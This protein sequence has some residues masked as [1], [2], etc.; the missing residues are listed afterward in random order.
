MNSIIALTFSSLTTIA[1]ADMIKIL[2]QMGTMA[3]ANN[4]TVGGL[5]SLRKSGPEDRFVDPIL[6]YMDPIL[7]YGCWCHFGADWI[8]AGGK[9][10]D[11]IDL[12]CKQLIQGYRCARMD[13][14]AQNKDCDAGN[15]NYT[16]YNFFFGQDIHADC[17]AANAGDDCAIDAC[18]IEGAF[19]LHFLSDFVSGNI[20]NIA[21]P[22]F[23]TGN[24][25]DREAECVVKNNGQSYTDHEC[26]GE[27]PNRAPYSPSRGLLSCCGDSGL[28]QMTSHDCCVD[29]NNEFSIGLLGNC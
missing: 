26:C 22:Q 9:V 17:A 5:Q 28:Y 13:A 18:V 16:P 11:D 3:K 24:G 21:D 23:Q 2:E 20:V 7:N 6:T 12:R 4:V 29:Q 27:Q 15:I 19:T 10:R 14:R 8:H 25:W 1:L